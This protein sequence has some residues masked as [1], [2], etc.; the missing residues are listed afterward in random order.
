MRSL[1]SNAQ[2]MIA[3][4]LGLESNIIVEIEWVPGKVTQYADSP[5]GD[6]PARIF[7]LGS[8]D[9]VTDL[10]GASSSGSVDLTLLDPDGEIKNVIDSVDVHNRPV[11]I[12][13]YF[14]GMD[15]ADKI[16]LFSGRVNSP[17]NW[18]LTSKTF[19][20]S[21]ITQ[22]ES[23][24]VG[25]S[26]EEGDFEHIPS[27][28]IG[29]AWPMVFGHA[30]D[31]PAIQINSAVRGSTLCGVGVLSGKDL[32]T[33]VA[34][35]PQDCS[36]G[37]SI[38]IAFAQISFLNACAGAWRDFDGNKY[39]ELLE[40]GND[41]RTQITDQVTAYELDQI[42]ANNRRAEVINNAE[43]SGEGCNP[44][45]I[46]GGED[47]PQGKTLV[48]RINGGLYTGVMSG[49]EFQISERSHPDNEAKAQET[50]E[51]I[52]AETELTGVPNQNFDFQ[53][54][55]P[56]GRGDFLDTHTI[57]RHGFIFCGLPAKSKPSHSQ[58]AR[59]SW[60]DAGAQVT[61]V[62]GE[63]ISYL[64]SITPGSV[65]AVK[66][67]KEFEGNRRLVNVPHN[68]WTVSQ[69]TYGPITAT[70]VNTN[71]PLSA[72]EG[73]GWDD[74]LY[75][76]YNSTIGPNPVE[77]MTYIITNY[78]NL[79]IDASSFSVASSPLSAFPMGF[80]LMD[81]PNALDLLKDLAFQSRCALLLKNGKVYLKYLPTEPAADKT[82][83][84][85]NISVENIDVEGTTTEELV[86][87]MV[88][89]WRYSY[90]PD[91]EE[92]LILRSN[93]AKYGTHETTYD[94]FAY[95]RPDIVNKVATFWLI[96]KSNIWKRLKV[97]CF[98]D[99]LELEEFDTVDFDLDGLVATGSAKGIV[100]QLSYD[101]STYQIE[102][103]VLTNVRTG[104]S[105]TYGLFWPG[106][107][108]L[109]YPLARD[110]T[111]VGG[112]IVGAL[113]RGTLPVG[114]TSTLPTGNFGLW[115]GGTNIVYSGQ[116]DIGDRSPSDTGFSSQP[117]VTDLVTGDV[118]NTPNPNP[119]LTL[120]FIDLPPRM[121]I[122]NSPRGS[123]L[124]DIRNTKVIDSD[125]PEFESR[126]DTVFA[127]INSD[128][129]LEITTDA[130]F[131]D[132][133]DAAEFLFVFD[134]EEELW[135]AGI[136]YLKDN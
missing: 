90:A 76:S 49:N 133:T 135:G 123:F 5:I 124:I 41:L 63:Q 44:L 32:H 118:D 109:A 61:I 45:P 19:S 46:L 55:V 107:T 106:N 125:N 29:K 85:S 53:M 21:V 59:H 13:Q 15:L 134:E 91:M 43:S 31:I 56:P 87:K 8:I 51:S 119:D 110:R 104:E 99:M 105:E 100:E 111:N 98:L 130:K 126:L 67:F 128:S 33:Q 94:F 26:A 24:E 35:G 50:F 82:L 115:N 42:R 79:V 36:L 81:R 103:S 65:T 2:T 47:F 84:F 83:T 6:I 18:S 86:T 38:G 93:V 74:T 25:F 136:A 101:S 112:A 131:T 102:L 12:Y 3:T 108:S 69:R 4:K 89:N 62:D 37:Q 96:R 75:V 114:D 28:M 9:N 16:L 127:G 48:L 57:R 77:I 40:Q 72:L 1:T 30:L 22:L 129:Q 70:F 10:S 20:C 122:P 58:V 64:V 116:A 34:L 54:D 11:N 120:N 52:E 121:E 66:A 17:L 23:E 14:T 60:A 27:S 68:L 97:T 88:V 92:T 73:E 39:S 95:N 78:T 113:A 132:G 71:T 117:V 7:S 80:A